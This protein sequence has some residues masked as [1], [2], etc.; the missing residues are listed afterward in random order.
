MRDETT[1]VGRLGDLKFIWGKP[2]EPTMSMPAEVR[3]VAN[4]MA[5]ED[6]DSLGL[7]GV[8]RMVMVEK[9]GQCACVPVVQVYVGDRVDRV[10]WIGP[11]MVVCF[12]KEAEA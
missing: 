8:T 11:G 12:A 4:A 2:V 7:D 9:A 5:R 10:I 1:T 3:C 6:I